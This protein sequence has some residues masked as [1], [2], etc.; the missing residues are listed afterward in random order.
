[1]MQH[2][3]AVL[4]MKPSWEP[5]APCPSL[6]RSNI[7]TCI[8]HLPVGTLSPNRRRSSRGRT[9]HQSPPKIPLFPRNQTRRS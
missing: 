4:F 3:M 1:M 6:T 2:L 9:R 8:L 7:G 5:L